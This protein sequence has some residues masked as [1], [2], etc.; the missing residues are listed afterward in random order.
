MSQ[1]LIQ[2]GPKRSYLPLALQRGLDNHILL[3]RLPLV[4][5]DWCIVVEL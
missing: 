2:G 1:R 5:L 4:R 3:V